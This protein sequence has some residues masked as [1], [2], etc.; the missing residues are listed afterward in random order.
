MSYPKRGSFNSREVSWNVPWVIS[1]V[2]MSERVEYQV[3][4]M[5]EIEW[6]HAILSDCLTATPVEECISASTT[7]SNDSAQE[8]W[9]RQPQPAVRLSIKAVRRTNLR[10]G[11]P[12]PWGRHAA[13]PFGRIVMTWP[14]MWWPVM[15]WTVMWWLNRF[16]NER[17]YVL[18]LIFAFF[19]LFLRFRSSFLVTFRITFLSRRLLS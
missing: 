3:S 14:V 16:V 12:R 2:V 15:W 4:L 7:I 6:P 8:N 19:V 10:I 18:L 11:F 17:F 13:L 5:A 1:D 9:L